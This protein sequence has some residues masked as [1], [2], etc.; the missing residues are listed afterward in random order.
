M[1]NV[2]TIVALRRDGERNLDRI[3]PPKMTDVSTERSKA[4]NGPPKRWVFYG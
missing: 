1:N 2:Q 4:P 3:D